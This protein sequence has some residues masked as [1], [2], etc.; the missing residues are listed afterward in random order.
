[1]YSFISLLAAQEAITRLVR[2]RFGCWHIIWIFQFFNL[3]SLKFSDVQ[4]ENSS[5]AL[6]FSGQISY[7]NGSSYFNC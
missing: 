5:G 4:E 6:K 1:M 7:A 3:K 2:L